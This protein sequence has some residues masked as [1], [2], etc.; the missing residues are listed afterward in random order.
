MEFR[1]LP[2]LR[3]DMINGQDVNIIDPVA[4]RK[5]VRAAFGIEDPAPPTTPVTTPV[6]T[7]DVVNASGTSGLAA[8]LSK[9]LTAKGFPAGTVSTGTY[10]DG[11]TTAIYHGTGA[12]T[13][14]KQLSDMLGGIPV[15]AS[16]SVTP[17]HVRLVLGTDFNLP[18]TLDPAAASTTPTTTTRATTTTAPDTPDAGKPVTTTIGGGIPCVN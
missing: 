4:I 17:G 15:S 11:T 10:S 5:E 3:Y 2:V 9:S 18:D 14:A 8:Q 6:S 1:T 12:D 13:D 7:L 16:T